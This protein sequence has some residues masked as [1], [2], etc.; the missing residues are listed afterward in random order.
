MRDAADVLP[1]YCCRYVA[2]GDHVFMALLGIDNVGI[3]VKTGGFTRDAMDEGR[4]QTTRRV[5]LIDLVGEAVGRAV[6]Q[7][8]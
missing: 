4:S 7:A 6:Y 5:T 3:F 1:T 2:A 8:R